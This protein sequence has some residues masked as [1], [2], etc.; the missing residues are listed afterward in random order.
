MAV[1][2]NLTKQEN[3]DASI[4]E[5]DFVTRFGRNWESL[6]Q[7]LSIMRPIRKEP[8]SKLVSYE[9]SVTL[10]DGAIPEGD[11]IPYSLAE[12][13]PVAYSDIDLLKYGKAVSIEAVN[14]WGARNAV[15]RTDNAFLNEL[16]TKVLDE[17]YT[18]LQTGTLTDT[19]DNFQK[20]VAMA[21]GRVKDKFKKMRRDVTEVV[22]FV[23][24]LDAYNYL[25][26]A[27]LTIQSVFGIDY[28]E[29]FM[30]ADR[31][32]ISSEIPSGKIIATPVDNIVL[33]YVDPS[34]ADF[35]AL[36]L[37]YTTDGVTNLIGIA[38]EGRYNH[39]VG[40]MWALM[41]MKLWAEYLNGIAVVTVPAVTTT[42]T[43]DEGTGA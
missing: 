33:Y 42:D 40:E 1:K 25:G 28:V 43:G 31:L 37:N 14:K 9:A 34:D 20:G 7:I 35:A 11:E 29:N 6:R 13:K 36:G 15:Q 4:R 23:N 18:F 41:G 10:E 5:I 19:Q 27:N 30:G 8:G 17:F 12:V 26:A 39:A 2:D 21:I 32:I 38:V 16:Q 22:V 3:I 24:T